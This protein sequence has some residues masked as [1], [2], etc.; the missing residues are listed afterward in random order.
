MNEVLDAQDSK[1]LVGL[2]RAGRLY[3]VESWI[4]SGKS[5]QTSAT[6]RTRPLH[7]A[8]EL[9][10][11][12]LVELLARNET[13]ARTKNNALNCAVEKLRMD[14]I[15]LLVTHGADVSAVPF[16]DVLRSWDPKMMRFS[17]SKAPTR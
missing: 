3:E 11:H 4:K 17:C 8:L 15:E 16:E 14:F 5:L 2:C 10:F 13:D 9:G 7:V 12:S 6:I 1:V